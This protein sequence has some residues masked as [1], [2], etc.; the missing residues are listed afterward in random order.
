[1]I[2]PSA[3]PSG[4]EDHDYDG[5]GDGYVFSNVFDILFCIGSW[6]AIIIIYFIECHHYIHDFPAPCLTFWFSSV[7]PAS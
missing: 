1:M 4:G 3:M 7:C 5:D 2:W 6:P